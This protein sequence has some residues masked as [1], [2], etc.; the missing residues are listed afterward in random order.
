MKGEIRKMNQKNQRGIT[1]IALVVTIIV[2]LILAGVT[3]NMVLGDDGIIGQAQAAKTAHQNAEDDYYEKE[4]EALLKI[5]NIRKQQEGKE[6]S[7]NFNNGYLTNVAKKNDEAEI[8]VAMSKEE[9]LADLPEGYSIDN[10]TSD[11]NVKNGSTIKNANGKKAGTVIIYGDIKEDGSVDI[12]DLSRISKLLSYQE[13][14]DLEPYQIISM[15]LNNDERVDENDLTTMNNFMADFQNINIEQNRT[16]LNLNDITVET[17][18]DKIDEYMKKV[19]S[20]FEKEWCVESDRIKYYK[21]KLKGA[22]IAVS[23]LKTDQVKIYDATGT[24]ITSGDV[25]AGSYIEISYSTY[26]SKCVV[27][28]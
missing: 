5:D 7:V 20:T 27:F 21:V 11:G 12:R 25:G 15:D 13:A 2:L 18:K 14:K 6:S 8:I 4:T 16:A 28:E 9:I 10:L 26:N 23:T 3:I 24:E 22:K 19:P 17:R 1:L